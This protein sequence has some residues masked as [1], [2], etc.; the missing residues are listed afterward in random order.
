MNSIGDLLHARCEDGKEDEL[1]ALCVAD[2][3]ISCEG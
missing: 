1:N 2:I 3:I